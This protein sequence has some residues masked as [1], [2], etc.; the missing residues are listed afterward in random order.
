MSENSGDLR[1][2]YKIMTG[3]SSNSDDSEDFSPRESFSKIPGHIYAG[4]NVPS[5][6]WRWM[7]LNELVLFPKYV[8]LVNKNIIIFWN[9]QDFR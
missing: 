9:F 6:F 2:K 8:Y 1:E 4:L 3:F 5:S 7:F